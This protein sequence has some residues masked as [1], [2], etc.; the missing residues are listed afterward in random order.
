MGIRHL[1]IKPL[2]IKESCTSNSSQESYSQY[3]YL[4]PGIIS[5]LKARRFETA[6]KFT[7]NYFHK[8]NVIDFGCADGPFLPSLSKY[9]KYV[10]GID[11]NVERIKRAS[12]LY[13]K[14][15]LDNIKLI[16]NDKLTI[17][18]KQWR[19]GQK[20]IEKFDILH[21]EDLFFHVAYI[22]RIKK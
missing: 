11:R 18:E 15:H 17:L 20:L 19:W 7:K 3:N 22:I 14:L 8:C 10:V 5:Y 9:F 2:S 6:L 21:K 1:F 12:K 13:N 16:C 4:K